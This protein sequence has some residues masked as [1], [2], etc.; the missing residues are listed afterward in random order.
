MLITVLS[1]IIGVIVGYNYYIDQVKIKGGIFSN[2]IEILQEDLTQL[3]IKYSSNVN[4]YQENDMTKEEF[5]IVAD[6]HFEDMQAILDRYDR[7][8]PPEP[9]KPSVELF[10]LSTESQLER[11]KQ[12]A[13]WIETGDEA[14]NIRADELHQES[15]SYEL[16]ALADFKSVQLGSNP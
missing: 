15:F 3:Q 5:Q 10:K 12:I 11:D 9:F 16:A 2:E 8:L 1:V 6:E 13:L 14:Y 7:L 4:I